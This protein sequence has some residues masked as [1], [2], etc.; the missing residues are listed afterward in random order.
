MTSRPSSL[1]PPLRPLLALA[2]LALLTRRALAA[3]CAA[4]FSTCTSCAGS[5]S[6]SCM[7]CGSSAQNGS[8]NVYGPSCGAGDSLF[9]FSSSCGVAP[10]AA[11]VQAQIDGINAQAAWQ[12]AGGVTG[13]V[14]VTIV[15]AALLWRTLLL[16]GG[17]AGAKTAA[18]D[19]WRS[20]AARHWPIVYAGFVLQTFGLAAGAAAVAIPWWAGGF[21]GSVSTGSTSSAASV[22]VSVDALFFHLRAC[23]ST[24][25]AISACAQ[26]DVVNII[27]IG[28][29][30]TYLVGLG[31]LVLPSWLLAMRAALG[32]KRVANHRVLPSTTGCCVAG[33][34]AVQGLAWGGYL[35]QSIGGAVMWTVF[36][37]VFTF[38]GARSQAAAAG[39]GAGGTLL[40]AALAA[41]FLANV[42]FSVSGCCGVGNMPGLGMSRA[43]CCCTET[44]AFT[45]VEALAPAPPVLV[46]NPA[47][48]FQQERRA[49]LGV[50]ASA[51]SASAAYPYYPAPAPAP[52]YPPQQ[53]PQQMPPQQ[54]QQ[55]QPAS[56]MPAAWQTPAKSV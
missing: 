42:L 12:A 5:T 43:N 33:L 22:Y 23:A 15:A 38:V 51:A 6:Y 54:Q 20:R 44:S 4:P 50:A 36:L 37:T 17:G 53:W 7:W 8:C 40:G 31:I 18:A 41:S 34:P 26:I 39:L 55:Q 27:M 49:A 28:G 29:A 25:D 16:D 45:G 35:L 2:A 10:P 52:T 48:P 9:P 30:G 1:P 11:V 47:N 21:S 24:T 3:P 56:E 32:L 14:L 13:A 46:A 19:A